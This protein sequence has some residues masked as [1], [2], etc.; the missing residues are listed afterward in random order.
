MDVDP[1]SLFT[2]V[3]GGTPGTV[4]YAS[5]VGGPVPASTGLS[6]HLLDRAKTRTGH[7]FTLKVMTKLGKSLRSPVTLAYIHRNKHTLQVAWAVYASDFFTPIKYTGLSVEFTFLS[8]K[9]LYVYD[10]KRNVWY[11]YEHVVGNSVPCIPN[12]ITLPVLMN[13]SAVVGT[14]GL[15]EYPR[16]QRAL[17]DIMVYV[18]MVN[19]T[20]FTV[21]INK[22]GDIAHYF[23]VIP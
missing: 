5:K 8:Y 11:W 20:F 21:F 1:L 18:K 19:K 15:T 14:C 7:P 4:W 2:L 10:L 12:M 6:S 3:T 17:K 23:V 16:E 13:P 22:L 9:P